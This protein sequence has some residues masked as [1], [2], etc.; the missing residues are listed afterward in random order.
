[1]LREFLLLSLY[2][3][4]ARDLHMAIMSTRPPTLQ[5]RW[6]A[7]ALPSFKALGVEMGLVVHPLGPA[8]GPLLACC[9]R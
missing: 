9:K 5:V 8:G 2:S 6:T 1:M 7:Q 4:Y 3:T